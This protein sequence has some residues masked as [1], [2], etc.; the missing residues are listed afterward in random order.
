M[1]IIILLMGLCLLF[2]SLNQIVAQDIKESEHIAIKD[3][4]LNYIEGWYEG[5]P[6][7]IAGALHPSLAKRRVV[8]LPQSGGHVLNQVTQYDM[9]EYTKAGFGKQRP[10]QAGEEPKVEILAVFK[11]TASVKIISRDFIDFAHL[12][13]FGEDWR[14]LNVLWEATGDK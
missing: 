14:I 2:S 13:K 6:E 4:C 11:G 5:K 8:P 9:I 3:A 7:R 12:A 1:K 10:L